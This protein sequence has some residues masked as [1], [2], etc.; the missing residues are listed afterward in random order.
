MTLGF[1]RAALALLATLAGCGGKAVGVRGQAGGDTQAGGTAAVG[2]AGN[3]GGVATGGSPQTGGASVACDYYDDDAGTLVNVRLVNQTSAPLYF[4]VRKPSC[5]DAPLFSVKDQN[6]GVLSP[7][8]GC[9]TPCD[10]VAE[11]GM[12][13]CLEPCFTPEA[14]SLQPGSGYTTSWSGLYADVVDLPGRCVSAPQGSKRC[15]RA[16]VI[17]PGTFTFSAY[18]GSA[19]DCSQA[20]ATCGA[21]P[22]DVDP[23]PNPGGLVSGELRIASITVRL[24]AEYGVFPTSRPQREPPPDGDRSPRAVEIVFNE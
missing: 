21:C 18:A 11:L 17:Q 23:C 13:P 12:Q 16:S 14:I 20:P 3:A 15:E 9:R 7:L 22:P 19:L 24:D 10:V 2:G 5:T 6:G 8:S 1:R 4:G